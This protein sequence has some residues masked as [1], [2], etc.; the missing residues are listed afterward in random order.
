MIPRRRLSLA[1]P[2]LFSRFTSPTAS[3]AAFSWKQNHTVSWFEKENKAEFDF[4]NY[5]QTLEQAKEVVG[6]HKRA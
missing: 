4:D 6:M 5:L 1:N 2:N 3:A